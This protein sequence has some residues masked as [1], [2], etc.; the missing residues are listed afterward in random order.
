MEVLEREF[1]RPKADTAVHPDQP[2]MESN[3]RAPMLTHH[4]SN[5]VRLV[6][7]L[8]LAVAAAFAIQVIF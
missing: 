2:I 8:T 5:V 4:Q 1:V 7:W 3:E 6:L